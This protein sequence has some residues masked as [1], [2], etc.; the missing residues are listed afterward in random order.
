MTFGSG[1][2]EADD[3]ETITITA[4]ESLVR[5]GVLFS[6]PAGSD[7]CVLMLAN[8]AGTAVAS[9]TGGMLT[10][11]STTTQIGLPSGHGLADGSVTIPAGGTYTVGGTV[12]SC[13]AGGMACTVRITNPG[14]LGG[15]A[16][17]TSSGGT[18]TVAL[19]PSPSWTGTRAGTVDGTIN[20]DNASARERRRCD[21]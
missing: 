2:D 18:A 10:A 7:D 13:P 20:P 19:A 16:T 15:P 3:T 1:L 11:A 5:G 6:C 4:G 21:N 17:G 12:I 9:Y 8:E 14:R